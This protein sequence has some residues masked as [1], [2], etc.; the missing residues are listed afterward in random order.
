MDALA[1]GLVTVAAVLA[2]VVV[3]ELIEQ[4]VRM[5]ICALPFQDATFDR[6]LALVVLHFV[7]ELQRA[8]SSEMSRVVRPGGVVA[9]AV[10]DSYGGVL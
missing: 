7:P 3:G 2:G 9:A 6:S 5:T 8:V 1:Y 4:P 10:W